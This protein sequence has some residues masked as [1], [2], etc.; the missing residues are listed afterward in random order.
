MVDFIERHAEKIAGVLS[1]LDRVVITGTLP[2]ICHAEAATRYL[3]HHKIRI[4][5]YT[6]FA[7]PRSDPQPRRETGGRP[8]VDHRVPPHP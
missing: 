8:W 2:D 5:D 7:E 3:F 1:C 6:Q 4:F